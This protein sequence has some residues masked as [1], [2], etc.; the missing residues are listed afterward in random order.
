MAAFI[1]SVVLTAAGALVTAGWH[2]LSR[3][4]SPEFEDLGI[5]FDIL[6]GAMAMQ[7][8]FIPGSHGEEAPVRWG[9]VGV[10]L[11]ILLAMA[12]ATRFLGYGPALTYT[13]P[14]EEDMIVYRMKS[15]A[16]TVTSCT[17]CAVLCAFWW[18]NVNVEWV[19][20]AWKDLLH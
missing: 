15:R 1:V 12:V 9:G 14:G 19:L 4:G 16:V 8:A 18:L 10:L 20:E 5:G 11:M 13:R 2:V 3:S 7:V 17:G 6:V